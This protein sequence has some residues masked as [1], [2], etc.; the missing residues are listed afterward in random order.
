M[1]YGVANYNSNTGIHS[2][3]ALK[4]SSVTLFLCSIQANAKNTYRYACRRLTWTSRWSGISQAQRL[5]S[6]IRF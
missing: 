4:V 2:M 1:G 5:N 6:I 3:Y